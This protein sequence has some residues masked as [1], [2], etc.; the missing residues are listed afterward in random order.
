MKRYASIK[1]VM[2]GCVEAALGYVHSLYYKII[3]KNRTSTSVL[4]FLL[5]NQ[6]TFL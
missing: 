1:E 5:I 4:V 6:L 3:V 2:E